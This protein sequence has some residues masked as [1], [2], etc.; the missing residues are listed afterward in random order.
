VIRFSRPAARLTELELLVIP[1]LLSAVGLLTILLVRHGE[2]KWNWRDLQV[3]FA[4]IAALALAS[5]GL[6]LAELRGDQVILPVTATLSALG[7]LMIQRLQPALIE[8]SAAYKGLA[9]KQLIYLLAGFLILL[10]TA[11]IFRRR[12]D[13]LRRYKYTALILSLGLMVVTFLFGTE[14]NGAKLWL[15]VGPI[16]IQPSEVV[17]IAL[18]VFLAAYLADKRELIGSSWQV[19]RFSLPP[20][21]YL[22]P[23]G[24]M[25][26]ASLMILVVQNDLGSALLFFGIFLVMLYVASNR[27]SYVIV[28]LIAFA[29]GCVVAYQLFDR[30]GIRVQNWLDPWQDPL[31]YGYQPIQSD[32]AIASGGII[33]TG[34][35]QGSPWLIPYVQTDFIF[36]AIAEE[37]GLLGGMAVLALYFLL[38][39]RGFMIGLLA[40]DSFAR[41]L[42]IGLSTILGLQTIIILGGVLRL[43]PLTGIT[44]PFISY[45]GS[46]LLTNFLLVG[47]LLAVSAQP[48]SER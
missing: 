35:G 48:R 17:K 3:S 31:V 40:K 19:G 22:L 27:I 21:P 46:S 26:A 25:W 41:L 39:M 14:V 28:G 34:L 44:L 8:R 42:A 23:M 37:L 12:L 36:S 13:W 5:V 16:Q 1:A 2:V 47:L 15:S 29:V 4:F 43:I 30:I 9:T 7:L 11:A 45:G 33:G 20:I 38:V 32:Y 18:V 24:L 10:A 6:S